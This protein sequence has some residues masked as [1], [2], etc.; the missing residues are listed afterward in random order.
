MSSKTKGILFYIAAICGYVAALVFFVFVKNRAIGAMW[1]CIAS[2]DILLGNMWVKR[3]D[4][5]D[6]DEDK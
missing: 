2:S 4:S 3:S 1:L 6:S 5:D